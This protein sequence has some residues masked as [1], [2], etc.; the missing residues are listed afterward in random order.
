MR[1]AWRAVFADYRIVLVIAVCGVYAAVSQLALQPPA[2]SLDGS[3]FPAVLPA[4]LARALFVGGPALL[5]AVVTTLAV[6][7]LS[8]GALTGRPAR[9]RLLGSAALLLAAGLGALALTPYTAGLAL[10]AFA[11]LSLY[12]VPA[13]GAGVSPSQAFAVSAR[14]ARARPW[15]AGAAVLTIAAAL[16]V[17]ALGDAAM[18]RAPV[19]G[20]IVAQVLLQAAVAATTLAAVAEWKRTSS[21][22]APVEDVV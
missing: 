21:R 5:A 16:L 7:V 10:V 9:A 20:S 8:G 6:C 17:G 11:F 15:P 22:N 18:W 13:T 1:D 19:V 3:P 12:V 4:S 2:S 14:L